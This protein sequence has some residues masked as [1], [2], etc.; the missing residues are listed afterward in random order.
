MS[1]W[2]RL[3]GGP[4]LTDRAV[5]ALAEGWP[6]L[7]FERGPPGEIH[8]RQGDREPAIVSTAVLEER[9]AQL[10]EEAGFASWLEDPQQRRMLDVMAGRIEIPPITREGL[11]PRLITS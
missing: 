7:R 2:K 9:V 6:E 11:L 1:W 4:D 10:G 5:A 3:F 8:T